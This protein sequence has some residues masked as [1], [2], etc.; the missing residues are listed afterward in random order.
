MALLFHISI[1]FYNFVL[2]YESFA[3]FKNKNNC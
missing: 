1:E 3:V 2:V